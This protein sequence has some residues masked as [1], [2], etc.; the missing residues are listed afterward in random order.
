MRVRKRGRTLR[1]EYY[2]TGKKKIKSRI[3]F[4]GKT[5]LWIG[6]IS[7]WTNNLVTLEEGVVKNVIIGQTKQ[8]PY[9]VISSNEYKLQI[10]GVILCSS[11]LENIQ[12]VRTQRL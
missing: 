9:I 4:I 1:V 5:S 3:D 8:V 10:E 12:K 6:K 7:L 11:S 2:C